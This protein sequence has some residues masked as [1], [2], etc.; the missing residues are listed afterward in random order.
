MSEYHRSSIDERVRFAISPR[1]DN[2]DC[3]DSTRPRLQ[4]QGEVLCT[5]TNS[6]WVATHLSSYVDS[7]RYHP[8]ATTFRAFDSGTADES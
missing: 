1:L 8:K 4:P 7:G 3:S 5:F 6:A 2:N